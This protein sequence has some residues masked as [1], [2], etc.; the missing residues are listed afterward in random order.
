MKKQLRILGLFLAA[1]VCTFNIQAQTDVTST[2][3]ANTNFSTGNG[4][5]WTSK[6]YNT[7]NPGIS[8]NTYEFFS[9]ATSNNAACFSLNQKQIANLPA[10][11][12]KLTVNGF[13]RTPTTFTNVIL[14]G[15]TTN[16]QYQV[17]LK[18]LASETAAYGSTPNTMAAAST[19]FYSTA[20]A[21]GYW[22]NSIDNIVVEDGKL[23]IGITNIGQLQSSSSVTSWTIFGNFKLYQL[24]GAALQP[25]LNAKI[26]AAQT[27][28]AKNYSGVAVLNSAISTAQ[29]IVAA[30]ITYNDIKTL[31]NAI[32]TYSAQSMFDASDTNPVDATFNIKNASFEDG[33]THM[34]MNQ[35]TGQTGTDFALSGGGGYF[36]PVG[37]TTTIAA[38]I[39][40]GTSNNW[41]GAVVGDNGIVPIAGSAAITPTNGSYF[42]G[43]RKRW[44]SG[45]ITLNQ[46]LA[47]LPTG[48][49]K[50]SVDLGTGITQATVYT[51][52]FT[53]KVNGTT[54]FTASPTVAAFT[55]FTSSN[56]TVAPG[57]SLDLTFSMGNNTSN[58]DY[59]IIMDNLKLTYYGTTDPTLYTPKSASNFTTV[60]NNV[61]ITLIG[62][63]L[64]ED[65]LI[66]VP[67][68]QIALSGAN[69]TGTS[70]NY[71][72][73]AANAN[74]TN[75][76]TATWDKSA[77]VSG[78]I[79][80]TSG[81][82][83]KYI[84]VTTDDV[85]SVS[86]TGIS[87][88]TG[89]IL[90]PA[91]SSATT[92]YTVKAPADINSVS[93]TAT[94]S[95]A[96][97]TVTNNG[98]PVSGASPS[99]VLTGN[100]YDGNAHT[101][102]YTFNWGG[103][104][105]INDWSANG[106]TDAA[107]SVPTVYGWSASPALTWVAAN[108][109]QAGTVRYMDFAN[110]ANAGVGGITY[111]YNGNN[112]DGRIMFV[113]WDG[114]AA[115]IYSYPVAIEA[116]MNYNISAKTAWN[117]VDVAP[118]LTF[119]VNTSKDNLGTSAKAIT[120][121]TGTA[122][123]LSDVTT[124][125]FTVPTTG[126]YYIN[127]T[128]STPSLCA[129]ADLAITSGPTTAV[130]NISDALKAYSVDGKLIVTGVDSYVVYNMQGMKMVD[131]KQNSINKS[132]TL[133]P[134]VYLVKSADAVK[135][136]IVK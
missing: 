134:G 77:N 126:I 38:A 65:I 61:D 47:G 3:F 31:Q 64:T 87:L 19:A 92:T 1:I 84:S 28:A 50:L 82:T 125:N 107:L 7:N 70:P 118:V 116:G 113:R 86:M 11:V 46:V 15:E 102:G 129:I 78:N 72:I 106:S 75:S 99:V 66:T 26:S 132:V 17:N 83:T 56:F 60:N 62:K 53:G 63:N 89:G 30:N 131:V 112:Y 23:N 68:T 124:G 49:Y 36:S 25:L 48:T 2:Y 115:R 120:V 76:I 71:T 13:T 43:S 133:V 55:T 16:K 100:S 10:G 117:S 95:P 51:G 4:N 21:G 105:T 22:L 20:I 81:T 127:I 45:V 88:S 24:T 40:G 42:F 8:S 135:K 54:I 9:N 94:T 41:D 39:V 119:N 110:G 12:Y 122:G 93:V 52:T 5:G 73:L 27:L 18:S 59:R 74:L 123:L 32:D 96:V 37:W 44:N 121:A 136:V 98:A 29:S 108:S 14:F 91:F 130:E 97:A 34:L 57:Q 101:S 109:T 128:S 90:L 69:V 114:S 79:S 6:Y 111:T 85:E 80:F 33:A 104:Y 103:N 58:L 35:I 67:S